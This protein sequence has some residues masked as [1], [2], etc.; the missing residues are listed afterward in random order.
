MNRIGQV[1]NRVQAKAKRNPALGYGT[2]FLLFMILGTAGLTFFTQIR[3]DQSDT[4]HRMLTK[5]EERELES[6]DKLLEVQ[7][8][9]K[10]LLSSS[11]E[12]GDGGYVQKRV[13]RPY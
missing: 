9:F 12:E 4:R 10:N 5:K 6:E 7:K 2:P 13:D 8:E 3:Y 11:S 1:F